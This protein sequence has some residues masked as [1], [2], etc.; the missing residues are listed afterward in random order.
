MLSWLDDA[1]RD[2]SHAM[3]TFRRSA[4]FA[5]VALLTLGLG[6]GANTAI[7]SVVNSVIL[8]PLHY[9]HPEQ[10]MYLTT[11][12]P[13]ARGFWFAGAEYVEFRDVN[14]SF[15]AVGAYQT[16]E[17]NLT[18][19]DRPLRV[20]AAVVD[21][22][23]LRALGIRAAYG[24]LFAAGETDESAATPA[25]PGPGAD[26]NSPY[27]APAIVILSHELWQS[28]FGGQAM[29][30]R[31]VPVNGRPHEVIGVMSPATDLMDYQPEVWLPL[32]LS[33]ADRRDRG[34]HNL[35]AIGRLKD[36][37]AAQAAQ[38]EINALTK[39]WRER[40]N[41]GPKD[42]TFSPLTD[43]GG[44][45]VEMRPLQEK[46]LGDAGRAI[47]VL[48]V[49]V[50]LVLLIVCANLASLLLARAETRRH[51][52]ALRAALGAS[53]GRLVR[54]F[55]TEGLL[56]SLSGGIIGLWVAAAGVEALTYTYPTSLPRT[57]E[58]SIDGTVLAF[59]FLL[60]IA[61][62][63][64]F[65]LAPASR[66]RATDLVTALKEAGDQRASG[67]GR[68]HIRGALVVAE[69]AIA[70]MLVIGAGL[71]VRTVYNLT[72]VDTGFERS[73]R[74]T[75]LTSLRQPPA[76]RR[77]QYR[78]LLDGLRAVPGVQS[79]AAMTGLPPDRPA[80]FNNTI[81]EHYTSDKDDSMATI[82][83]DQFVMG[84][85]FETMGIPIVAGRNFERTD[86]AGSRVVIVNETLAK[87]IWAD[88]NPVGQRLR[89]FWDDEWFTVVGV[90]RDVRQGGVAQNPG[91][92]IYFFVE[93]DTPVQPATM[94]VVLRTTLPP[95]SLQQGIARVVRNV[96]P[97]VPVARLRDMDTVF[98]E[99]IRRPRLLAQ[100]LGGFAGLALLLA[101]VGTYGVLSYMVAERRREIGI[102]IA[103]GAGRSRVLALVMRQ[104]LLLTITGL[105]IGLGG[106]FALNSLIT[107]LLFGVEP[108]DATTIAAVVTTIALVAAVACGLPA[109]RASRL[110]PN[111]VLRTN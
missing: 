103:L 8:R 5:A 88:R 76:T 81:F 91:T 62:G 50:G 11:Q 43:E 26:D 56:L 15:A 95:S 30:G 107:S 59:A 42:H 66:K 34:S 67:T 99:S 39:N 108:T 104:G 86:A 31:T 36:G 20:R 2:V 111:V 97:T 87:K 47:W 69:V 94:N 22:H 60:S 29:V 57:T 78:E 6:I 110:D 38:A 4:G 68:H 77:Q 64:L 52:L 49:A 71:L 63:V 1:V 18:A 28:A 55:V 53:R 101:A 93:Q 98:T 84:D 7:F 51:E 92:E 23:L 109:L 35:F 65:G 75:F 13:G 82:E 105:A 83:Y 46:I 85:Y 70:V 54:Q 74:V 80:N 16:G 106:A 61:T 25:S 100:L 33:A 21:D 44:H 37:V 45:S 102:R 58:V 9:P 72:N 27:Q 89:R 14:T 73:R 32:G 24:R 96:D 3:R 19:G 17:V 40:F 90:A 79:A 41:L 48:Q 12:Y 10:L